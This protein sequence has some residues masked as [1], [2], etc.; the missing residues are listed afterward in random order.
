MIRPEI[1]EQ[2]QNKLKQRTAVHDRRDII[3][4]KDRDRWQ[5]SPNQHSPSAEDLRMLSPDIRGRLWIPDKSFWSIG[6]R[7]VLV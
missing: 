3:A 2:Q 7:V 5:R 6:V 4:T 1:R